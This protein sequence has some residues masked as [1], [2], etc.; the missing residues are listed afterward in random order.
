LSIE[1]EQFRRAAGQFATGIAVVTTTVDGCAHGMTANSFTSVSL[2]PTL[3][4]VCVD[5]RARTRDYV[6]AASAFAV[7][8]LAEEQEALS[9]YFAGPRNEFPD[10]L[11]EVPYHPGATGSPIIEGA[12]AHLDCR[13]VASYPGGDH[14]IYVGE[15]VDANSVQGRP[16][17]VY[18]AGRYTR[19]A[20]GSAVGAGR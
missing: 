6:E 13:L 16:P 2:N 5:N 12:A 19:L 9:V 14:T 3:I 18:H 8:I 17:L 11:A 4:L 15:V 7:N 1:P 20:V 10:E